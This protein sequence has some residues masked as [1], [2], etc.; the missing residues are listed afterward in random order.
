[1]TQD[2]SQ[3]LDH[4]AEDLTELHRRVN[5]KKQHQELLQQENN[6]NW[7]YKLP[8]IT[9]LLSESE[10]R[11]FTT[12]VYP[13]LKAT[14]RAS[15]EMEYQ[16]MKLKEAISFTGDQ[17]NKT[18]ADPNIFTLPSGKVSRS[19]RDLVQV[20]IIPD[21]ADEAKMSKGNIPNNQSITEGST[22]TVS[23]HDVGTVTVAADDVQGVAQTV[24]QSQLEDTPGPLLKYMAQTAQFG[25]LDDEAKVCFD[26]AANAVS[27]TNGDPSTGL[28]IRGDTG[29]EIT[30]DDTASVDMVHTSLIHAL[31]HYEERGYLEELGFRKFCVLHPQ[32]LRQLRG[33]VNLARYTQHGDAEITRT[34]KLTRLHGFDLIPINKVHTT[35]GQTNN[36]HRA[37]CGI[38]NHSFVLA[39]KR[40]L[41]IDLLKEPNKS[42]IDWMWNHRKNG[43]CF[44]PASFVRIST[45]A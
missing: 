6:K 11:K 13:Q 29:A 9:D 33:D 31:A 30:G 38:Y 39:E 25:S 42:A 23:T 36:S 1:M 41:T 27:I 2:I 40:K 14:G 28:W 37:V 7:F 16:P 45:T 15:F 24:N 20:K 18:T 44:D 19:I 8:L 10:T 4:L 43:V 34:G 26:D 35:T 17:S 3:K 5:D 12:E 32:Q 22:N 21:G